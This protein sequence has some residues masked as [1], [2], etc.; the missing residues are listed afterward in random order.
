MTP[1][2]SHQP[3]PDDSRSNPESSAQRQS[4]ADDSLGELN[5]SQSG[6]S[7]EV[8]EAS[9]EARLESILSNALGNVE[10]VNQ[11]AGCMMP[12]FEDPSVEALVAQDRLCRVVASQLRLLGGDDLF[13][14]I[15]K[16]RHASIVADTILL[17]SEVNPRGTHC[18]GLQELL[19]AGVYVLSQLDEDRGVILDAENRAAL[20]AGLP[21]TALTDWMDLYVHGLEQVLLGWKIPGF[22]PSAE[23]LQECRDLVVAQLNWREAGMGPTEST[24]QMEALLWSETLGFARA[25]ADPSLEVPL[26]EVTQTLVRWFNE[27]AWN[28]ANSAIQERSHDGVELYNMVNWLE[29]AEHRAMTA[30][31]RAQCDCGVESLW[32]EVLENRPLASRAARVA[33]HGLVRADATEAAKYISKLLNRIGS[34]N[35]PPAL[36]ERYIETLVL[37]AAEPGVAEV[38]TEAWSPVAEYPIDPLCKERLLSRVGR[39]LELHDR[40]VDRARAKIEESA[41]NPLSRQRIETKASKKGVIWSKRALLT[42]QAMGA[43]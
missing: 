30:L 29:L 21:A 16:L 25:V 34:D 19:R 23:L 42:L 2:S 27:G 43:S 12:I 28:N 31:L 5:S 24:S 13:D 38:T 36:V 20:G 10:L 39:R 3:L 26:K 15:E 4:S 11:F 40:Y 35:C 1:D 17:S 18:D 32:K 14:N 41:S 37:I 9:D 8:L 7:I 33:L 6:I 22:E